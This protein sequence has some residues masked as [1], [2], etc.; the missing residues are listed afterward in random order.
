MAKPLADRVIRR[1]DQSAELYHPLVMLVTSS[2]T[3]K[4]AAL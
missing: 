3:G 1:I 4:T 2:G